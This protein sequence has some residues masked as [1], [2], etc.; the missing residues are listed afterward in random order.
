MTFATIMVAV[1]LGPAAT[2]R[3]KLASGIAKRFDA[4]LIGVAAR[5]TDFETYEP[6]RTVEPVFAEGEYTRAVESLEQ[7]MA[8]FNRTVPGDH[9][10]EWR[11]A[12]GDPA[13]YLVEQSR[14]ADIIVIGRQAESDGDT[15]AS[16]KV[17]S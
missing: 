17:T 13:N 3:V 14:A 5:K 16:R 12:V 2:D 6:A 4:M 15:G 8:L 7:A 1:D 11:G 10:S 9:K